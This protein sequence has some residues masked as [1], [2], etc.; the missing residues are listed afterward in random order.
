MR[1]RERK[2]TIFFIGGFFF[3]VII[4]SLFCKNSEYK[5]YDFF[6]KITPKE[7]PA[8]ELILIEIEEE[9]RKD[10]FWPW[11]N[12]W[13]VYLINYLSSL[14]V[15]AIFVDP[16]LEE[17][18]IFEH[19][20]LKVS[21]TNT[22]IFYPHK[23]SLEKEDRDLIFDRDKKVRRYSLTED[24][25]I[26]KTFLAYRG[27]SEKNFPKNFL[28]RYNKPKIHKIEK[29]SYYDLVISIFLSSRGEVPKVDFSYFKNKLC[30]IGL[31]PSLIKKLYPT[32]LGW[33]S[34]LEI[35]M[36]ALNN[37]M[38]GKIL[39]R[40]N[41]WVSLFISFF[42]FL[43]SSLVFLRFYRFKRVF[44]LFLFIFLYLFSSFLLF[45][46]FNLWIDNSLP[47]VSMVYAYSAVTFY[48]YSQEK[49]IK[50]EEKRKE[51]AKRLK[52]ETLTNSS[53]F[54]DNL[55]IVIKN[56]LAREAEGDFFD[57]VS[58]EDNRFG[59]LIGKAPGK[60]LETVNYVIKLL[61]EFRLEAPLHR[62]PRAVLNKINN[63]LFTEGQKGMFATC[64]YIILDLNKKILSFANAGNEPLLLV[65]KVNQDVHIYEALDSTPLGIAR[66]VNFLDQ[67]LPLNKGDLIVGFTSG[68]IEIKN[69]EGKE[70]GIDNL[71]EV[72]SQ[73]CDWNVS[74]LANKVFEKIH[75]FSHGQ[76]SYHEY[77][78]LLIRIKN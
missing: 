26:L 11:R 37:L 77:T 19:P 25:L 72:L 7:A 45:S 65:N 71:K 30:I 64:L 13:L 8:K 34:S 48:V 63:L 4:F 42:V 12:E 3:L 57:I 52:E 70:F 23:D 5:F 56:S 76:E 68:L 35:R 31:S 39:R 2:T 78:L 49:M 54:N 21:E 62:R 41:S 58:L 16:S 14:G 60:N 61:N 69:S 28:I 29:Y 46:L 43:L 17:S 32:P 24:S 38:K 18:L 44:V 55:E 36:E 73:Y 50:R 66:N 20:L 47:I 53:L 22:F 9:T 51:L 15:K 59:I 1:K 40:I 75:R 6:T 10:G 33:A 74:K 67:D 27:L